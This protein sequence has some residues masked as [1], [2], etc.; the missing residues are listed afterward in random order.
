MP[1]KCET[2]TSTGRNHVIIVTSSFPKGSVFKLFSGHTEMQSLR[3]QI[4][5]VSVEECSRKAP[6]LWQ[7][8]E[9][10]MNLRF[11]MHLA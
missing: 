9:V 4:S 1:E 10:K 6:Y 8:S 7:M 3:F 2:T 11:Q 5:P